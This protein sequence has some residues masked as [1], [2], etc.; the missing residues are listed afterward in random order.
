MGQEA[1]LTV[2][3]AYSRLRWYT[4]LS[5]LLGLLCAGYFAIC[6]LKGLY[7]LMET[8]AAWPPPLNTIGTMAV[9]A[10]TWVYGSVPGVRQWW[11]DL[12]AL[13]LAW[14]VDTRTLLM[15]AGIFVA[16]LMKRAA[17]DLRE[18]L[19][20]AIESA[21]L[22][23]WRDELRGEAPPAAVNIGNIGG[24]VN[25]YQSAP[26]PKSPWWS[27]PFGMLLIAV[28]SGVAAAVLGQWLNLELGLV[29]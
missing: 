16:G 7:P 26:V 13:G 22:A 6:A 25:V 11:P 1:N 23:R 9:Q 17:V 4:W 28:V 12:S 15:A 29:K 27:R 18:R 8:L 24:Q 10:I 14:L 19:R 20:R 21:Q 2:A 5:R 3:Q